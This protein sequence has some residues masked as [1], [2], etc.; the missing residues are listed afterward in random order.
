MTL[1]RCPP[2]WTFYIPFKESV[3]P[4]Q[5][6]INFCSILCCFVTQYKNHPRQVFYAE[7]ILICWRKLPFFML[8]FVDFEDVGLLIS[9]RSLSLLLFLNIAPLDFVLY[10][11]SK[12]VI[13]YQVNYNKT[14]PSPV[15]SCFFFKRLILLLC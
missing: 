5:W 14:L 11:P 4:K 13:Y 2:A 8:I 12:F 15:T 7:F 3:I 6:I 10:S 1:G 9:L